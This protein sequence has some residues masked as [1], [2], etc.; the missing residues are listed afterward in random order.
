MSLK[1]TILIL[2]WNQLNDTRRCLESLDKLTYR[3]YRIILIDNGSSDGSDREL[4]RLFP[5][6]TLVRNQTNR[7]FTGGNNVGITAA[8]ES[9]TDYL[10]LLNNDTVVEPDFLDKL[11]GAVAERP[12]IGIA[13]PKIMFDPDRDRLWFAGGGFR[14]LLHKTYHLYYGKRDRGMLKGLKLTPWVSGCA[15]LIK[16]KVI[17]TV[18]ALD[19]KYFLHYED[20]DLC[21][22]A[23]RVG[24][25]CAVVPEAV[26]YHKF[27]ASMSGKH[28]PFYAYFRVRNS[29][30]FLRKNRHYLALALTFAVFPPYVFTVTLIKSG[31]RGARAVKQ[32]V[33]DFLAGRNGYAS[34]GRFVK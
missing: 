33:L 12:E 22:R 32:A 13:S 8:M 29:L 4:A 28:S 9:D 21:E 6:V 24:Y 25:Y 20:V 34:A 30:F 15:M 26:I 5:G 18:G 10:L 31:W 19:E 27:A 7:G 1:V 11:V 3:N 16:R 23:A 14:P 2:N 17:E